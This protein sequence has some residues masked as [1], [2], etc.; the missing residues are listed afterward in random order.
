MK[1][2][3]AAWFDDEK[4]RMKE[5]GLKYGIDIDGS[6]QFGHLLALILYCDF[7]ALSTAFSESF[8]HLEKYESLKSIKQRNALYYWMSRYLR[9]LVEMRHFR[10]LWMM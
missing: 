5:E 4:W 10:R 6:I 9:E 1:K 3:K 7:T 8:R 2:V